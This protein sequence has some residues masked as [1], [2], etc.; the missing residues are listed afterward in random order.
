MSES[1][2]STN[3]TEMTTASSTETETTSENTEATTE[4]TAAEE[5][6][7]AT[8]TTE[9]EKTEETADKKP[10]EGK[11]DDK[12]SEAEKGDDDKKSDDKKDAEPFTLDIDENKVNAEQAKSFEE[13]ANKMGASK[14]DAQQFLDNHLATQQKAHEE[15]VSGWAD[16]SKKDSEFGGEK[17]GENVATAKKALN[18][19]GTDE[20]KT[21]MDATG[22]GSHPEVIRVFSRIGKAMSDDSV[23]TGSGEATKAQNLLDKRYDS[24][25]MAQFKTKQ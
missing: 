12:D 24:P 17:Y 20:L 3:N 15:L 4:L 25:G 18:K 2:D 5:S 19:Y 11:A 1:N 14:E 8:S 13:F 21:L 6:G 22:I 9:G 23:V 16:E 7:D 10:D